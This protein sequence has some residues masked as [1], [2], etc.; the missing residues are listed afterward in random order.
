MASA[1]SA[2]DRVVDVGEVDCATISSGVNGDEHRHRGWPSRRQRRS[3]AALTTAPIAMCMT[4]FSG[5]S[6]RSWP[7]QVSS[8]ASTPMSAD[9]LGD[10]PTDDV[11]RQ[12]SHGGAGD[13]VATAGREEQRV[14]AMSGSLVRSTT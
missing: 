3:H 4:P 7:S 8:R 11:R 5:P 6:Q 14:P 9:E 2:G 10:V 13:V 12:R 1:S